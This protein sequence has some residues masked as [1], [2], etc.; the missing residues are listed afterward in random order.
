MTLKEIEQLIDDT[1]KTAR[2]NDKVALGTALGVLEVA[3]QLA[4]MNETLA[5]EAKGKS[6][7][8]GKKK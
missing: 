7:A 5:G 1:R 8:A 2:S 4:I 6:A 3:R